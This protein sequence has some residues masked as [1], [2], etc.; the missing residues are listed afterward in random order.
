MKFFHVYN[1]QFFEG[2]VKNELLNALAEIAK[3]EYEAF[4]KSGAAPRSLYAKSGRFIIERRHMADVAIG[5]PTSS[6]CLRTHLTGSDFPSHSH[7]FVELMYV[8]SGN[9]TH[10][11]G[12]TRVELSEGDIL[13]LGRS[14]RH[15]IL[16]TA[17]GDIGINVII[18]TDYFD[19]LLRELG[20]SSAMPDKLFERMLSKDEAEF[21]VFKTRG[22]LPISNIMENLAYM[23]VNEKSTDIYIMQT[24]LSLLFAHLA[25]TPTLLSDFSDM[26]TYSEQTKRKILNYIHT[27]YRTAT[28]SEAAEMLDLSESHLSRWIKAEFGSTFKQMLCAKRFEVACDMLLNTKLSVNDIILNVGYEN[29]SYFHKQFKLRYGTTP[30]EYRRF[31]S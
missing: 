3:K 28:L 15:S 14:T 22:D 25:T 29:S 1:E 27:S 31:S 18:S 13:L 17:E 11:I 12:N 26:N 24:S 4:E 20:K 10:L 9:I 8:C 16:P 6:I 2:L 21:C 19:T 30:K 5:I 23:L 7:D